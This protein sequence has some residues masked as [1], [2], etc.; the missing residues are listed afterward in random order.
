MIEVTGLKKTY[1]SESGKRVVLNDISFRVKKGEFVCVVGSSGSGK[2]TLLRCLSGMDTACEGEVRIDGKFREEYFSQRTAGFVSQEY[3]NLPWLTVWQNAQLGNPQADK[4][5]ITNTLKQLGLFSVRDYFPGQLS[6][7]MRQRVAIARALLQDTEIVFFDEPFGAL[8]VQTRTQIQEQLLDLWREQKK[9]IIFVTHDIDEAIFLADRVL[10]LSADTGSLQQEISVNLPRPRTAEVI[11][12]PAFV[13]LKKSI[14]YTIR[15]ESIKVSLRKEVTKT[16]VCNLGLFIWSGNAP[17]YYAHEQ[18]IF[19]KEG[20]ETHLISTDSNVGNLKMLLEDK[21]DVLNVTLDYAVRAIH[22]HP[23]LQI[24]FPLNYSHGGDAII[25]QPG[26]EKVQDLRGRKVGIERGAVS[27]FFLQYLLHAHHLSPADVQEVSLLGGDIGS[28]LIRGEMDAAVLW[29][30]WLSKAMELSGAKVVASTKEKGNQ[31]LY[32][33]LIAKRS[34]IRDHQEALQR[35]KVIWGESLH[36]RAQF[37]TDVSV[38]STMGISQKDVE[39]TMQKI[40][41]IKSYTKEFL[42]ALEKIQAFY[43]QEGVIDAVLDEK[44]LLSDMK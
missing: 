8:D 6:G 15:A 37:K 28:A 34:Y 27:H 42:R 17:W 43:F 29:E 36:H 24:V 14:V 31:V 18:G 11:F 19:E 13:R 39:M 7:G 5:L 32:D 25:A 26:I 9:T 35:L 16:E 4:G 41:F 12:S 3:S 1:D 2:S 38:A 30:P 33:V 20:L 23:E 21:V 10:I 44:T 40:R 22:E